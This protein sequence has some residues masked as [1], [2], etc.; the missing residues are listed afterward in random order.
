MG[1]RIGSIAILLVIAVIVV[2]VVVIIS[3]LD[4]LNTGEPD[5]PVIVASIDDG[6][7]VLLNEPQSITV[8]ISSGSPVAT[9]ELFVDDT[10]VADVIPSYSPDRGAWIG[11]FVWT[12]ERLG[13]ANV[14]IVTLD[15]QGVESTR[16]IQVEVTDDQARVAASLRVQVLGISPLQQFAAGAS[17]RLAISATGS[18]AVERFDMLVDD[19]HVVSVSPVLDP[20]GQYIAAIEWTPLQTGEVQV[21]ISATDVAG[22]K[23]SETIPVIIVPQGGAVRTTPAGE[24]S[25]QQQDSTSS[26]A[27]PDQ[28]TADGSGEVRIDAPDD[29]QQFILDDDFSFDVEIAARNTGP[30]ASALLYITPVAPNNTLGNSVLIHSS[31]GHTDGDY[32]ERIED[33]HRW[34]TSSG[35]YEFQLVVFTPEDDRYDHRITIHVV[36]SAD[37]EGADTDPESEAPPGDEI[38]LA[39][40]TARQ[41]SDDP[42]RLNVSITNTSSVDI[43]RINVIITVANA[44][45]GAEIA[46]A[47]VTMG[48]EPEGLRTIPLDL[49][50]DPGVEVEALVLLEATADANASNNIFEVTLSPPPAAPTLQ[51]QEQAA[52]QQQQQQQTA[53]PQQQAEQEP[54]P[55]QP[56]S[57]PVPDLSVLDAQATS[58]GYVLLTVLNSGDGAASS[59]TVVISDAAGNELETITRRDADANPL[60]PGSAEILTSLI[61]HSGAIRIT[62]V[63]TPADGERNLGNNSTEIEVP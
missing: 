25:E 56:E 4:L 16:E 6:E 32:R 59:F 18:Q 45:T 29:G 54:E 37:E 2:A 11:S 3:R 35:T 46:S 26:S 41:A 5:A 44:N 63:A 53:E 61:P 8:T 17:I 1:S 14:R 34:I 13:F 39:I 55:Q 10:K 21:T 40:V 20:T 19:E 57:G 31:E 43:E 12:P 51:Q 62:V 7:L 24:T 42:R 28:S 49:D 47:D 33:V 9:L 30:V 27:D 23:E 50:I 22:R 60:S 36:A 38:D 15:E 52:Q 48:I 58:D